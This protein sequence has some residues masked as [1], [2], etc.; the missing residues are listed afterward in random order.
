MSCHYS[1][2]TYPN[3]VYVI[4]GKMN[5][6]WHVHCTLTNNNEALGITRFHFFCLKS[7]LACKD[8]EIALQ[9]CYA[10]FLKTIVIV[11]FLLFFYKCYPNRQD[12][13]PKQ[14][15]KIFLS[16]WSI[17]AFITTRI[18]ILKTYLTFK[19]LG[20]ILLQKRF[21]LVRLL[22]RAVV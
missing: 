10:L 11:H 16:E 9:F 17:C 1:L 12:R 3:V 22:C 7:N 18:A 21:T 13:T 14:I 20:Y 6:I 19:S 2:I 4:E 15:D 8:F 5:V